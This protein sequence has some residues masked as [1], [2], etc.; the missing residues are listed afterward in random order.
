MHGCAESTV[1][2]RGFI[3]MDKVNKREDGRVAGVNPS[4]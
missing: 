1:L 2:S 4:L 3:E